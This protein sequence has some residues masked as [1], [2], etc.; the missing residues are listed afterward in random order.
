MWWSQPIKWTEIELLVHSHI[1]KLHRNKELNKLEVSHKV[2]KQQV[3]K[4]TFM[5]E[6]SAGVPRMLSQMVSRGKCCSTSFILW[7]SNGN[8][9]RCIISWLISKI[10]INAGS[11]GNCFSWK[12]NAYEIMCMWE[13][14]NFFSSSHTYYK[15]MVKW[16]RFKINFIKFHVTIDWES[17]FLC[18]FCEYT[19]NNC[20]ILLQNLQQY[21]HPRV[22]HLHNFYPNINLLAT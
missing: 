8:T 5:A 11:F 21:L 9:P 22:E 3:S 15:Y 20:S 17:N 10:K 14:Y 16:I 12:Y 2:T 19:G 18:T 13:L 1:H 7:H 4:L 6:C